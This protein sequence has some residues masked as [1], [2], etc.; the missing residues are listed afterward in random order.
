MTMDVETCAARTAT[1]IVSG[2]GAFMLH[3]DTTARGEAVGLDFG[4]FYGL[5]R[6]GVLGDV[7]A[8]VAI[9]SFAFFE[10]GIVRAIW[11]GART[12]MTPAEGAAAYAAACA[13]WGRDH[14]AG[15]DGLDEIARLLE[16][17]VQAASPV[18]AP[19]FAGWRAIPPPEDA[20][21]RVMQ[22]LHVM[23]ELRGG[24]HVCA[25]LAAG[26]SPAEALMVVNPDA[27][28]MFGWSEPYP[29]PEPHR[30]A[31]AEAEAT[32]NRLV[33]PAFAVLDDG[34]RD[35]LVE[36]LDAAYAVLTA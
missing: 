28:A 33:A 21:A 24:L 13:E 12:K 18:G 1:P 27:M 19:L 7:D 9:A 10:P 36:L 14:L 15:V 23:R 30:A 29:D 6:G 11:D 2:G 3:P 26:L 32:T 4:S 25:V 31:H 35:R 17:V 20:P 5:G 22:L 34:E 16:R 8:D